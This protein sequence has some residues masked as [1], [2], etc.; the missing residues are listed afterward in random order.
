[1]VRSIDS[2]AANIVTVTFLLGLLGSAVVVI[3]SFV[4]DFAELFSKDDEAEAVHTHPPM[5]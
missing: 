1:M 5:S 2:Y 3:I 4:E